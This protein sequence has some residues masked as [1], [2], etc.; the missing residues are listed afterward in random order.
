MATRMNDRIGEWN[1]NPLSLRSWLERL[2][3][4]FILEDLTEADNDRKMV[5]CLLS[6]VGERGYEVLKALT[7]PAKPSTKK[8]RELV[9]LL[10]KHI[11]PKPVVVVERHKFH[12]V[13]QGDKT[14]TEFLAELRLAA[15]HCNFEAFYDDALRDQF[16][17]GL[18]DERIRK[19]LLS[20]DQE[21]NLE[22]AFKRP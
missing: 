9:E 19:A 10:T 6:F 8:Y 3:E 17:C 2:E 13:H 11:S 22:G 18:T 7:S 16:I 14:V 4:Y 12:Q 21:L 20:D 1:N 15:E 5:A